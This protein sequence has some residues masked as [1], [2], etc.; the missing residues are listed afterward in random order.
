MIIFVIMLFITGCSQLRSIPKIATPENWKEFDNISMKVSLPSQY[1]ALN[2]EED[3]DVMIS[4]LEER[5]FSDAA[6]RI[7]SS[8]QSIL[9]WAYDSTWTGEGCPPYIQVTRAETTVGEAVMSERNFDAI[10][11]QLQT[12]VGA[13]NGKVIEQERVRWGEILIGHVVTEVPSRCQTTSIYIIPQGQYFYLVA[14]TAE[15]GELQQLKGVF[16]QSIG[17]FSTVYGSENQE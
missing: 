1:T 10:I 13:A 8:R 16:E 3:F 14:Y 5:G 7:Q 12:T 17:T 11:T 15:S 6:Q 9:F 2:R 4:N